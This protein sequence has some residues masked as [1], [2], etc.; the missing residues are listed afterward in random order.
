MP[1]ANFAPIFSSPFI[2]YPLIAT[3][4]VQKPK[5]LDHLR[6]ALRPRRLALAVGVPAGKPLEE[7]RNNG[8]K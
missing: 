2:R 5:L 8:W 1:E 3:A 7:P 6:E 4:P